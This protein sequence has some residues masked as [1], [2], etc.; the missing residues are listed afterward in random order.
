MLR[1]TLFFITQI[2][3]H[4]SCYKWPERHSRNDSIFPVP[5][6]VICVIVVQLIPIGSCQ[7]DL[8]GQSQQ[9]RYFYSA[10]IIKNL[11]KIVTLHF[12]I[13]TMN[14]RV[15]RVTLWRYG[16]PLYYTHLPSF[17]LPCILKKTYYPRSNLSQLQHDR[18]LDMIR[19]N[20]Q[21][22]QEKLYFFTIHC[23]PPSLAYIAVRDPQRSQ[24]NWSVQSLLLTGN[25]LYNQ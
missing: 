18:P 14:T 15:N 17:C 21:G 22:V 12:S 11:L 16:A 2:F 4:P 23:N 3:N 13:S 6:K 9:T 19:F 7:V 25:F 10:C 1:N 24:R 20:V 8:S 5:F